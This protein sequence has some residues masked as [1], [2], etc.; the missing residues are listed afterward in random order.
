MDESGLRALEQKALEEVSRATANFVLR[1]PEPEVR[2]MQA[3]ALRFHYDVDSV[4]NVDIGMVGPF[5]ASETEL[6]VEW[7][8]LIIRGLQQRVWPQKTREASDGGQ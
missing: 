1:M 3:G 8:G 7:L 5:D 6:L 4:R 2:Y